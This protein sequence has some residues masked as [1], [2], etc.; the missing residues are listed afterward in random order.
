MP[1]IDAFR[2]SLPRAWAPLVVGPFRGMVNDTL[3][4]M[5]VPDG[6]K[7]GWPESDDGDAYLLEFADLFAVRHE[8]DGS[9][10][11]SVVLVAFGGDYPDRMGVMDP[12]RDWRTI[13]HED[14]RTVVRRIIDGTVLAA[15]EIA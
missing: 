11:F 6:S 10:P 2:A 13:C 9:T 15:R 12:R 7:E 5:F 3:T 14:G 4:W 1:D 8:E